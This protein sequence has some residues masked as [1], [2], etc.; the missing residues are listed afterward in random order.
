MID[1]E[2][3]GMDNYNKYKELTKLADW[4]GIFKLNGVSID[5]FGT[6]K[7]LKVLPKYLDSDEVVF[8]L[9]SGLMSQTQTS[10]DSDWGLNTWLVALTS[11]RF[12]FMD[13][14]L[15]TSSVNTQSVRHENVQAVSASQGWVFGK[16]TIDLGSRTI[17]IDNCNKDTV[18]AMANLANKWFSVLKRAEEQTRNTSTVTAV[19]QSSP[20]DELKK[21]GELK[22]AGLLTDEEFNAAKAKILSS[23]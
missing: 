3:L 1:F 18:K 13:H 2:Q 11:T 6:S 10:D 21:L 8:S 7:E 22:Q 14:A 17:V 15:L 23:L 12:L 16:I 20:L 19:A 9:C 4:D 5:K